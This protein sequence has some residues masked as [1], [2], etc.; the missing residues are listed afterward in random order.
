[1][2]EYNEFTPTTQSGKMRTMPNGMT[3]M[4]T[5]MAMKMSGTTIMMI[6]MK[7]TTC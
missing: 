2:A 7:M 5:M 4:T 3:I 1:M 6:G